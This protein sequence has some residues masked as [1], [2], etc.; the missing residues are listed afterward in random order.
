ML[1]KDPDVRAAERLLRELSKGNRESHT[2]ADMETPANKALWTGKLTIPAWHGYLWLDYW[3]DWGMPPA[4]ASLL[5][6]WQETARRAAQMKPEELPDERDLWGVWD[7]VKTDFLD[8]LTQYDRAE[9]PLPWEKEDGQTDDSG[10]P[11]Q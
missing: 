4:A 10:G 2:K 11:Q 9:L 3:D 7:T 1:D 8:W 6:I 5:C